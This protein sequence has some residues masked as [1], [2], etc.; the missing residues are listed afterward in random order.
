M[1]LNGMG[2]IF[3]DLR[4]IASMQSASNQ[5]GGVGAWLSQQYQAFSQLPTDIQTMQGQITR[6]RAVL[7]AAGANAAGLDD[8]QRDIAQLTATLPQAQVSVSRLFSALSPVIPQLQTGTLDAGVIAT[9][10]TN[11]VDIVSTL[12]DIN[13]LFGVRDSARAK[14]Q[15]AVANPALSPSVAQAAANAFTVSTMGNVGKWLLYGGLAF[16]GYKLVRKVL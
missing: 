10:A 14:I 6:V 12:N 15:A 2:D 9:L 7:D 4:A 16:V 13:T 5:P 3:S 8:A 1:R 11:G